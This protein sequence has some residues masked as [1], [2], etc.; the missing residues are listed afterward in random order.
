MYCIE[1]KCHKFCT[2]TVGSACFDEKKSASLW[3]FGVIELTLYISS[4]FSIH[5]QTLH[6]PLKASTWLK[7]TW[8][9]NAGFLLYC[10]SAYWQQCKLFS[11]VHVSGVRM[12][13]T[14]DCNHYILL[15]SISLT[16]KYCFIFLFLAP[17][18][19]KTTSHSKVGCFFFFFV[20]LSIKHARTHAD[21]HTYTCTH[22]PCSNTEPLHCA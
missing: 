11:S 13:V 14:A 3:Y 22:L 6:W 20:Y 7:L 4:S 15:G 21:R 10:T 19:K 16:A 17:F 1:N 2:N 8:Q 12:C 18:R 9:A 5:L